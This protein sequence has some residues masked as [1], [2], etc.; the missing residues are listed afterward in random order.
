MNGLQGRG[1]GRV[2]AQGILSAKFIEQ[3]RVRAGA[4]VRADEIV[5]SEVD[6][7]G[8]VQV[9]GKHGSIVGGVIHAYHMVAAQ[10]VGAVGH[11]RT[12]IEVGT[13]P[14]M[15]KRRKD[16]GLQLEKNRKKLEDV[17]KIVSYLIPRSGEPGANQE[18]L[19]QAFATK[20]SYLQI[21]Q[22]M[23]KEYTELQKKL[24][25]AGNGVIHVLDT[26][27]PGAVLRIS[28]LNYN[29]S[30][31][32]IKKTTFKISEREIRLFPCDY[33]NRGR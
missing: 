27:Y 7:D 1:Q 3:S 10:T 6:S 14:E 8:D 19:Q 20:V 17:Q 16:L 5:H 24:E 2:S 32:P 4:L 21:V 13:N 29:V 18:R 9:T 26:I 11:P 33:V 31:V 15:A 22:S 12:V 23:E 28:N 25:G 30:R